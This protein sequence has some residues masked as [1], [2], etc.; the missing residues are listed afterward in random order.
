MIHSGIRRDG[1]IYPYMTY[2][3]HTDERLASSINTVHAYAQVQQTYISIQA[4]KPSIL[5]TQKGSFS[6]STSTNE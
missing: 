2:R 6:I 5:S 1:K 3:I 4:T